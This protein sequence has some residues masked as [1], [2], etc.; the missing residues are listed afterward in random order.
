MVRSE[1]LFTIV[2]INLDNAAGL[3]ETIRSVTAQGFSD[4][5][6]IVIDGGSTDASPM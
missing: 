1:P 6:Y 4:K 5:E 2:T 3:D